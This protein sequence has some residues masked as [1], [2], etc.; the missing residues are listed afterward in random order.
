MD[1]NSRKSRYAVWALARFFVPYRW[2][3]GL[4]LALGFGVAIISSCEPLLY[5]AIFDSVGRGARAVDV[6]APLACLAA[7]FLCREGVA[8]M[9]DVLV[10]RV[11]IA[12]NFDLLT[13][14]IERLHSLPL[15]HHR[16]AGVGE[17]MGKVER[18]ISA[19][20]AAFTDTVRDLLPSLV[21]LV[22]STA[23]MFRLDWRLATVTGLFAPIPVLFG[24]RASKE[25]VARERE[26]MG[27]W[28]RIFAR[29]NEVLTAIA[30]VKSFAKEEDEKQRF[31][32]GV[33]DANAR[34]VRG[35]QTDA[36]TAL[37]KNATMALVRVGVL[38]LGAF[39]VVRR[40]L[41]LG[42]LVAFVGYVA[43]VFQPIQSL[44]SIYQTLCKGAVAAET[45]MSILDAEDSLA[46]APNARELGTVKGAVTFERVCFAYRDGVPVLHHIDLRVREGETVAL[47][48]A[49]GAGKSTLMGL[50]QR[51]YDPTSGKVLL[52]GEDIRSYKQRSL[53][54]RIGVVL[55]DGML[56]D[57][58][59]EDN[60]LFGRPGA[61]HEEV[62]A[63][64][65]AANAHDFI[66]ALPE[67]YSTKIGERGS[68]LSGGE[69]QRI[70]IARALLKD[71][72]IL[73]LDEA[74]SALD[75]TSED[76]VREALARLRAG[77]TTFIIAHRLS[78]VAEAD[79]IIVMSGGRIVETGRHDELLMA[80]GVYAELV[81]RQT[82]RLVAA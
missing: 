29:L 67:G 17:I 66:M 53:R 54:R 5:K 10:W 34:V 51:F 82:R 25:Q 41:S 42:T 23:L 22:S 7:V 19:S 60:I 76:A 80:S 64:A 43:G 65:R 57:D 81:S 52:D 35:V 40:E 61:S 2:R 30:V 68:R 4:V 69:R 49:S 58:T 70:A 72:P 3:L 50:L 73:I 45:V 59:I 55:Q 48:G 79:R 24:A 9:L 13:A 21:Y 20:M 1:S 28:T 16:D 38:G 33:A 39:L 8:A 37:A 71:A 31:L 46:D 75:A 14:T 15:S 32:G 78:T 36:K 12:T 44:T 56:F 18:G 63:A 27:R 26:L 47:V 77:R 74:T 11:R 6:A 62:E